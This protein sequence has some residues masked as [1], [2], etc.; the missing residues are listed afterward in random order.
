VDVKVENG[1]GLTID[2]KP[3][4][5]ETMLTAVRIVKID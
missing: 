1:E 2:L 3:I 5:G 4:T